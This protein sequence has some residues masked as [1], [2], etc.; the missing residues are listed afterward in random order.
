MLMLG[1]KPVSPLCMP[2]AGVEKATNCILEI[3]QNIKLE[4]SNNVLTLK[5]GSILTWGGTTYRT[6]TTTEDKTWTMPDN[7]ADGKYYIFTSRVNGTIQGGTLLTKVSSGTE[8]ARPEWSASLIGSVYYNIDTKLFNYAGST[9]WSEDWGVAYPICLIE[10]SSGIASFAKDS[11][12]NDMI[13]NG[14][15]FVG[16]HVV[17]YP[18][19]KALIPNGFN[20]D[21][22]YKNIEINRNNLYIR[23][24]SWGNFIKL[25][26]MSTGSIWSAVFNQEVNDVEDIPNVNGIYY[27]K[28]LNKN[29]QMY[30][31]EKTEYTGT[32]FISYTYT[33]DNIVTDFAIQQPLTKYKWVVKLIP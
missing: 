24:L 19:V 15:C 4:L 13:F 7:F 23:E 3:P 30:N 12:G 6:A 25:W 20:A 33:Y 1:R 14:A 27:V 31:N 11:N 8:S 5:S 16:H 17:V 9:R 28:N 26:C 21:G 2:Y 29:I 22:S 10:V 32:P 18:N